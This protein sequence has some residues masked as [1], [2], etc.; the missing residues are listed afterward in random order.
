MSGIFILTERELIKQVINQVMHYKAYDP[1]I[2]FGT[3]QGSGLFYIEFVE[4]KG[5]KK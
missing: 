1:E 5:K 2:R 3:D 4:P